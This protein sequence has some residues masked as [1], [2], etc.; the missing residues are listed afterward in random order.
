MK[1][2][3]STRKKEYCLEN[4]LIREKENKKNK[5][6]ANIHRNDKLITL[7]YDKGIKLERVMASSTLLGFYDP[8]CTNP[9]Y[10]V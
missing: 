8:I 5:T 6:T 2:S 9:K 10:S 3:A 4:N 7:R 1:K